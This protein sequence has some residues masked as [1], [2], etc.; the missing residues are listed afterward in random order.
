MSER[1][2]FA[3]ALGNWTAITDGDGTVTVADSAA[4]MEMF[5]AAGGC[6]IYRA[7]PHTKD[8]IFAACVRNSQQNPSVRLRILDKA[9]AP[10]VESNTTINGYECFVLDFYVGSTTRG[11]MYYRDT[12]GTPQFWN[13]STFAWTTTA[14]D[15]V[16]SVQFDDSHIIGYQWDATNARLRLF[17][18]NVSSGT[19]QTEACG[20]KLFGLTDW[21]N[22]S[23]IRGATSSTLWISLGHIF[24]NNAATGTCYVEWTRIDDGA[25]ILCATNQAPSQGP[26]NQKLWESYGGRFWLPSGAAPQRT[27]LITYAGLQS[28][29]A[30]HTQFSAGIQEDN[31]DLWHFF[32]GKATSGGANSI[33]VTK[34]T[35]GGLTW[36]PYASNPIITDGTASLAHMGCAKDMLEPDANKRYKIVVTAQSGGTEEI[37][38]Y[39]AAQ[40]DTTSWT[41]EGVIAEPDGDSALGY[42]GT[43]MNPIHF[44]GEWLFI[45]IGG[46]ISTGEW[47]WRGPRLTVADLKKSPISLG[48]GAQ[49][50]SQVPSAI[51]ST[52]R[53]VTVPDTTGFAEDGM[54]LIDDDT[55]VNDWAI[56]R[57]RKVLSGT[58]LELYHRTPGY[59]SG[60]T[61]NQADAGRIALMAIRYD[62]DR[63]EWCFYI[64][65]FGWFFHYD[66]G[67]AVDARA[68]ITGLA[69]S[70]SP[71]VAPTIDWFDT[72]QPWLAR[73]DNQRSSENMTFYDK[74]VWGDLL[75][76]H[77]KR[78]PRTRRALLR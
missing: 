19:T 29:C 47:L 21:V 36:T 28:W 34:S 8:H 25:K 48:L 65:P 63:R 11:R 56:N 22:L 12:G 33:G 14:V 16:P 77:P 57:V 41:L 32:N 15:G 18:I 3:S 17:W 24:N 23:S 49:N 73:N 59:A 66:N 26:Y 4:K 53:V 64:T 35:D 76:G 54:V 60:C 1:E 6:G 46:G 13:N 71:L 61:I 43:W 55:S 68:E 42:G 39:T 62:S 58:E 74:P 72:P 51:S 70:S 69:V 45:S 50:V 20:P 37:R 31:G 78:S 30:Y 38:L 52:S 40:P 5:G 9:T 75:H 44:N 67:G 27:S 7:L 10:V 2:H